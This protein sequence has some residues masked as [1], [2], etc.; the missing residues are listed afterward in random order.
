MYFYLIQI[1]ILP[2]IAI[3]ESKF[4]AIF[5]ILWT[6]L[7]NYILSSNILKIVS[8]FTSFWR[9]SMWRPTHSVTSFESNS[10]RKRCVL[11][12]GQALVKE[13]RFF[14]LW[15]YKKCGAVLIDRN[16]V[17][18][19]AHCNSGL[20]GFRIGRFSS[21]WKT[22]STYFWWPKEVTNLLTR[23]L[24]S[25]VGS[26]F[27]WYVWY[28]SYSYSIKNMTAVQK[29]CFLINCYYNFETEH[30]SKLCK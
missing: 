18:T 28:L 15:K 29:Y 26:S 27:I 30:C 8:N 4:D 10:W 2:L 5:M 12:R 22:H 23:K 25:A 11:W 21:I 20:F 9:Y 1:F 14:G 17:I 6:H 7:S 24:M 13:S 3:I 16:G 19:T